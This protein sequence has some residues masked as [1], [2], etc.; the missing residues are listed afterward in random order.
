MWK[1]EGKACRLRAFLSHNRCITVRH[2]RVGRSTYRG[3]PCRQEN[4]GMPAPLHC[5]NRPHAPP[6]QVPAAISLL[7]H[8]D[9]HTHTHTHITHTSTST[10]TYTSRILLTDPRLRREGAT[11]A[12]A[13]NYRPPHHTRTILP[14]MTVA[15][16]WVFFLTTQGVELEGATMLTGGCAIEFRGV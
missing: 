2:Q 8:Q 13:D 10:S 9:A 14:G 3:H 5:A 4:K 6:R 7:F 1:S 15:T 12:Q 11:G 16:F